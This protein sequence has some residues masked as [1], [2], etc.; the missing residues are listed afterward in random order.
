M[1]RTIA[2]AAS[3][4]LFLAAAPASA[5]DAFPRDS[6]V[7]QMIE[8]L[9]TGGEDARR[10]ACKRLGQRRDP[11]ALASIGELVVKDPVAKVRI[12]C[13][14]ALEDLGA[15][16]ASVPF[17][18]QAALKDP[19]RKMREEAMDALEDVDPAGGGAVAAQVLSQDKEH[20]VRKQACR[21]IEHRKWAAAEAAVLQVVL[22]AAENTELRRACVQSM[23]AIGSDQDYALAHKMMTEEPNDDLRKEASAQIEHHPRA[24]SIP[25]LCRA[26]RDKNDRIVGNAVNGLRKL[27]MREGASCLRETAKTA[28][29]DRHAG[30][31]N[32]VA[33]ELEQR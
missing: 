26:L 3:A 27:G 15:N 32:K 24:D 8:Y 6:T 4:V 1:S 22:G 25:F 29:N 13:V 21:A 5:R 12:S 31:M 10:E 18:V 17:V 30:N 28:K 2:L 20:D 23:V 9:K 7:P 14:K 11:S 16:P 33:G 19:D